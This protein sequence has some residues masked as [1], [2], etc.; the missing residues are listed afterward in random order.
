MKKTGTVKKSEN[1]MSFEKALERLE[2]IVQRLEAGETTL[3]ESL[4]LFEEGAALSQLCSRRLDEAEQKI[5][6][7]TAGSDAG[8]DTRD[9]E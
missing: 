4:A 1:A 5:C 6:K 3:D 7:I 2:Q 8:T 9:G